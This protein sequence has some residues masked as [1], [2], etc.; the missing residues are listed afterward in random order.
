MSI[1]RI[2]ALAAVLACIIGFSLLDAQAAPDICNLS[3]GNC[4]VAV[5]ITEFTGSPTVP[6][7]IGHP[8]LKIRANVTC[9]NNSA[10]PFEKLVCGIQSDDFTFD[11]LGFTHTIS[12][13]S[14]NWE[15]ANCDVLDYERHHN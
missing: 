14:G 6:C 7:L 9:G 2:I 4:S 11:A 13:L 5:Q 1:R 8:V 10:G 12:L 3:H 15:N